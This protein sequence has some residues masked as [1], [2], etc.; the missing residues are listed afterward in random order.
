MQAN[1]YS[2][3]CLFDHDLSLIPPHVQWGST[4][5]KGVIAKVLVDD[6]LKSV[7]MWSASRQKSDTHFEYFI[8]NDQSEADLIYAGSQSLPVFGSLPCSPQVLPT[9]RVG[10]FLEGWPSSELKSDDCARDIGRGLIVMQ[11]CRPPMVDFDKSVNSTPNPFWD[12][13]RK[14]HFLVTEWVV[15]TETVLWIEYSK[16]VSDFSTV[17]LCYSLSCLYPF[18]Q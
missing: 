10:V 1:A 2:L 6:T 4:R 8:H 12:Q 3:I 17:V 7:A 13:T 18:R 5:C 9:S 15:T 14:A 16:C 11:E